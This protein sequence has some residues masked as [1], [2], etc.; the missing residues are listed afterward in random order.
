L[1]SVTILGAAALIL[2]AVNKPSEGATASSSN[3]WA[4][5]GSPVTAS[6]PVSG[7]P[8]GLDLAA[9]A[10]K[11]DVDQS[12]SIPEKSLY[13]L[14]S[15]PAPSADMDAYTVIAYP[16][17]GLCQIRALS[18]TFDGDSLGSN[19]RAAAD[20]LADALTTKY[21]KPKKTDGCNGIMCD[22]SYWAMAV[23]NGERA[24]AYQWKLGQTTGGVRSVTLWART[25]ELSEPYLR[26]DYEVN[27]EAKCKAAE[28]QNDAKSL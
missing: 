20:R 17:I 13:A 4:G 19:V 27:D 3:S 6:T 24:Y 16:G 11:L 12:H 18:R 28:K 21:G 9:P 7:G 15:V 23:M 22:A 2:Y 14:N 26:L 5:S 10:S 25:N 8:F 1:L